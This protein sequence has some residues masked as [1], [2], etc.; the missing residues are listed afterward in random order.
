MFLQRLWVVGEIACRLRVETRHLS[1]AELSEEFRE[2]DAADR[3]DCVDGH[4]EVGLTDGFNVNE[5]EIFDEV[6]VA[7]VEIEVFGVATKVVYVCKAKVARACQLNYFL[8]LFR[9]K[10]LAVLVEKLQSVPLTWVVAG[11]DDDTATGAFHSN[12]QFSC[13][14]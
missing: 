11:R 1:D 8:S 7:L 3:V 12:R 14:S 5:L 9:R 2:D 6:D 4:T 13:W 10:E